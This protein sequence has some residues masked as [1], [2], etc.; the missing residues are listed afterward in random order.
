M[1]K[2]VAQ[3][4]KVSAEYM[5]GDW[6]QEETD[7]APR[8]AQPKIAD[9]RAGP[10]PAPRSSAAPPR[11]AATPQRQEAAAAAAAVRKGQ[12]K[13]NRSVR[14]EAGRLSRPAT[15]GPSPPGEAT[16]N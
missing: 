3:R 15:G 6:A 8:L 10:S 12:N 4:G 7:V 9:A 5:G 14:F 2:R 1:R 13:R 16:F 11:V